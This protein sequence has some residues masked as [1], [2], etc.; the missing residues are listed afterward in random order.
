M[1]RHPENPQCT[2]AFLLVR[3]GERNKAI[4]LLEQIGY[5]D[6]DYQVQLF[7]EFSKTFTTSLTSR[8]KHGKRLLARH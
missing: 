4:A 3:N 8:G 6:A 1:N 2:R 5:V 7:E